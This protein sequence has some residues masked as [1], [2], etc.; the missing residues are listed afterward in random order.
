[1][2]A[3]ARMKVAEYQRDLAELLGKDEYATLVVDEVKIKALKVSAAE[4]SLEQAQKGVE[5]ARKNLEQ[6][7]K[8]VEASTVSVVYATKAVSYARQQLEEAIITAPFDG[9]IIDVNAEVGDMVPSA[10]ST[11]PVIYMINPASIEIEAEIDE[12][13]VSRVKPEQKVTIKMD[14]SPG[15]QVEGTVKQISMV[16]APKSTG[17]VAYNVKVALTSQPDFQVRVG[18]SASVD[19]TIDEHKDV[20]LVPNKA[21]E[22][23]A[24]KNAYVKVLVKE[25]TERLPVVTGMTDGIDTEIMQGLEAGNMLVVATTKPNKS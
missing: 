13:D 20:L 15:S 19:I 5:Q 18:M 7:G 11:K 23:D 6:A 9:M 1:M 24:Q 14:A 12:I 22:R 2:V 8:M 25:K 10:Q 21:I 17:I 16:P 4:K 3:A